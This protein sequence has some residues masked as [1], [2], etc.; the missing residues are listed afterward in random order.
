M[1]PGEA[2]GGGIEPQPAKTPGDHRICAIGKTGLFLEKGNAGVFNPFCLHPWK[3]K[4]GKS[5]MWSCRMYFYFA[6]I[7]SASSTA[8][9]T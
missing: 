3:K 7:A 8:I 4:Y 1:S 5:K 6:S 9:L 2:D